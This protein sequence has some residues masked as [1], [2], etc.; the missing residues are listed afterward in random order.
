M[1]NEALSDIIKTKYFTQENC[2]FT[3]GGGYLTLR[4][5]PE[6]G[7][8]EEKEY[9]RVYLHRMFPF[10]E[11]ER[12]ISV[13][14]GEKNELGVI[15]DLDQLDNQTQEILRAELKRKYYMPAILSID[16][17][18][19]R[20]GFTYWDVTTPEGKCNFTLQD[21]QR[22]IVKMGED[23]LMIVDIDGNRYEIPHIS[24]LDRASYKRIELYL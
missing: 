14:D 6:E 20:Y 19:D 17:L 4:V 10:E 22:S 2:S 1:A 5:L 16:R 7:G 11:P 21:T 9:D 18:K 15:E 12:Y 8:A 23:R 3:D 24:K 13:L